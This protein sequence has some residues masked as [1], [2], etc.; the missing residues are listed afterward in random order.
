MF[1]VTYPTY[2]FENFK[3]VQTNSQRLKSCQI[4]VPMYVPII[5]S[6]GFENDLFW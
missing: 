1:Q 5:F 6:K 4:W 3:I 2:I